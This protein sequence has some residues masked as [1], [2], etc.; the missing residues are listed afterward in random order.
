MYYGL[1]AAAV[2]RQD[3]RAGRAGSCKEGSNSACRMVCSMDG[4]VERLN[5]DL[6]SYSGGEQVGAK[7]PLNIIYI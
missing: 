5:V 1:Y 3:L 4:F 2:I 7:T 6:K